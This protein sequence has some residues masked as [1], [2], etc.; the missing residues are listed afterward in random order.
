MKIIREGDAFVVIIQN[1][2]AIVPS[3]MTNSAEIQKFPFLVDKIVDHRIS[4][5]H[6]HNYI[7]IWYTISGEYYH[8]IN[9][10]RQK[11]TAGSIA[12]VFPFSVHSIDSSRSDLSSTRVISVSVYDHS[13]LESIAPFSPLT[14]S[15]ASFDKLL[16]YPFLNF[17]GKEKELVDEFMEG[18]YSEYELKFDMDLAKITK[19]V[20]SVLDMCAQKTHSL[21]PSQHISKM[22]SQYDAITTV[23]SALQNME[24][25]D[26]SLDS[27]CRHVYMSKRQ[28]TEKFKETTGKTFGWYTKMMKLNRAVY[29][30]RYS[31]NSLTEI[32]EMCGF[33]TRSYLINELKTIYGVTPLTLKRQMIDFDRIHGEHI[34]NL[35]MEKYAWRKDLSDA[36][37][38]EYRVFALGKA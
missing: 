17:F 34:H 36:D 37:K 4:E 21:I 22:R 28:F 8:T 19:K 2:S 30:L 3:L 5:Q 18:I 24:F 26:I 33:T 13:I 38:Y 1:Q 11:Q 27:M 6:W 31:Q 29:L 12:L 25:S 35:N 15:Y 23:T 16:L 20:L 14:F 7:Q 32:A 10:V 9:G